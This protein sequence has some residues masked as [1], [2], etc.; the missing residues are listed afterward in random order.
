MRGIS[1]GSIIKAR[2]Q[3]RKG[4]LFC[5]SGRVLAQTASHLPYA[6]KPAAAKATRLP[7][8]FAASN[9]CTIRHKK[10]LP[11]GRYLF[12]GEKGIRTLDTVP[13]IHDFQSCALDQAQPSLRGFKSAKYDTTTRGKKQVLFCAYIIYCDPA[14]RRSAA[15]AVCR[16]SFSIA[17]CF[18]NTIR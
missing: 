17:A 15:R 3:E 5:I 18:P 11:S 14:R 9:P 12:G 10:Y 8:L 4:F 6:K 2:V 1:Y 16:Q 7:L 13:R